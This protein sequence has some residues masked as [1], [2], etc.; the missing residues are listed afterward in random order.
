MESMLFH[1]ALHQYQMQ[2]S[3]TEASMDFHIQLT[4]WLIY[5]YTA[6]LKKHC[7]H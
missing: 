1:E 6:P 2:L 3:N 7:A 5:F 4:E